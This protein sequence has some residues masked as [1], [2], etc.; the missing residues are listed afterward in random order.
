MLLRHADFALTAQLTH[1]KQLAAQVLDLSH[2]LRPIRLL[3][4]CLLSL[5]MCRAMIFL[6]RMSKHLLYYICILQVLL[7]YTVDD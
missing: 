4:L 3:L 2:P 7:E 1:L 5:Y 6:A